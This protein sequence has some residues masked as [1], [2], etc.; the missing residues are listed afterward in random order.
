MFR[1]LQLRVRIPKTSN[2]NVP[3]RPFATKRGPPEAQSP[4]FRHIE[5]KKSIF[6]L[7]TNR[8]PICSDGR[9]MVDIP[10]GNCFWSLRGNTEPQMRFRYFRPRSGETQPFSRQQVTL[11]RGP[12]GQKLLWPE[13]LITVFVLDFNIF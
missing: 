12:G 1:R 6:Q 9:C 7:S 13:H 10:F 5:G 3:N 2:L 8:P 4:T 11:S